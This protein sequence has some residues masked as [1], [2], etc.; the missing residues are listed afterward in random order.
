[1]I[2]LLEFIQ[3]STSEIPNSGSTECK[4]IVS[5]SKKPV[6]AGFRHTN[7]A[8]LHST[9]EN[10]AGKNLTADSTTHASESGVEFMVLISGA[11]FWC[12]CQGL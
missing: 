10:S 4:Q 6:H 9:P 12:E 3:S 1:V 8:V 5:Q 11:G 7:R 2:V